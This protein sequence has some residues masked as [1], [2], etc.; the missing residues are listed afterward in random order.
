VVPGNLHDLTA[1]SGR[2]HPEGIPRALDD[3][4]REAHRI[5]L[6]ETVLRRGPAGPARRLEREREAEHRDRARLLDG[7][8]RYARAQG[9]AA[10]DERQPAQLALAEVVEHGDPGR[11]ELTR[12]SRRAPPSDAIGLLDECDRESLRLRDVARRNEVRRRDAAAGSVA[13]HQSR[14]GLGDGMQ[15]DLRPTVRRVDVENGHG[16]DFAVWLCC[17]V[18]ILPR[19]ERIIEVAEFRIALRRFLTTTERVARGCGLT[20]QQHMLLLQIEGS[21]DRSRRATVEQ[22][23]Q[24]LVLDVSRITDLVLRAEDDGLLEREL[25]EDGETFLRLTEDG[26]RRLGCVFGALASERA[27]FREAVSHL[28]DRIPS[29]RH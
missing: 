16:S 29:N 26:R 24:R 21:P 6:V 4:G 10:D 23:A 17:G 12:R 28:Q 9:P 11:V 7:A 25:G 5:Q 8:A 22:L 18:P 3:Q 14:A 19:V 15:V 27:E 20:A 2:R 1:L 13:E